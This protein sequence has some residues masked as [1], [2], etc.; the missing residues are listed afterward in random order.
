MNKQNKT[1]INQL[2][3][4]KKKKNNNNNKHTNKQTKK[5]KMSMYNLN[6]YRAQRQTGNIDML[7]FIR[8]YEI[9]YRIEQ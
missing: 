4:D 8:Y 2:K 7:R 9:G 5:K 1:K 6:F 3:E